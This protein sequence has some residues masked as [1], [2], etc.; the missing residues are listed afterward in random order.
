MVLP[1]SISLISNGVVVVTVVDVTVVDV[2]AVVVTVVDVTA[3]V[4]VVVF[5]ESRTKET[6]QKSY[7]FCLEYRDG[8]K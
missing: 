3:A 4:I 2:T 1:C 8:Q 7:L 5:N 6:K